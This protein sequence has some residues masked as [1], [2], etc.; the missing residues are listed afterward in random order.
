[1]PPAIENA[2]REVIAAVRSGGDVAIRAF[3]QKF[4][5]RRLEALE[6]ERDEWR[7]QA[8][9]V[10]VEVRPRWSAPPSASRPF[11]SAS[12]TPRSRSSRRRARRL[13][14]DAAARV[15]L[16]VPG[17]TARYPSTVLMTAIPA[18]SPACARS[19]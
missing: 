8:G 1:M 12:A 9:N 19:S 4:E 14:R 5:G 6:L 2:A 18:K 11:T 17:G 16:Y 10:A 13:A 15:G 7:A 3:T